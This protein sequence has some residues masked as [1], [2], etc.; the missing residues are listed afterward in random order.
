MPRTLLPSIL[1]TTFGVGWLISALGVSP[2]VNWI[3]TLGLAVIGLLTL[4]YQGLNKFSVIVGPGFIVASL[5]SVLRQ[6]GYLTLDVEA[7]MLVVFTGILMS[8]AHLSIFRKPAWLF[9]SERECSNT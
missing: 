2:Q 1:V 4:A 3:W 8:V 5:F 7:P 6:L 9:A